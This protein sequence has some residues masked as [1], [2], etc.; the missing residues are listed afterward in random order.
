MILIESGTVTQARPVRAG[1]SQNPRFATQTMRDIQQPDSTSWDGRLFCIHPRHPKNPG[2]VEIGKCAAPNH[3][4]LAE[5]SRST[6]VPEAVKSV[7]SARIASWRDRPGQSLCA[8]NMSSGRQLTCG[9]PAPRLRRL[10]A[11]KMHHDRFFPPA[12]SRSL[13]L[14]QGRFRVPLPKLYRLCWPL[15]ARRL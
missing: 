15:E 5:R 2:R 12:S 9:R 4:R 3:P 7:E 11:W 13:Q 1:C 10:T 6:A 8:R 14:R